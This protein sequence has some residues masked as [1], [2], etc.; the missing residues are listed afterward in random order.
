MLGAAVFVVGACSGADEPLSDAQMPTTTGIDVNV[1]LEKSP[2]VDVSEAL[3]AIDAAETSN[4]FCDVANALGAPLP[5][6]S[7]PAVVEVYERLAALVASSASLVPTDEAFPTLAADWQNL[8]DALAVAT[9]AITVA[10]GNTSDPVF[11]AALRGDRAT[12]A[13]ETVERFRA[14]RCG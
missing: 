5:T 7:S 6:T 13:A 11:V 10:D 8:G 9:E 14:E 4:D 2:D 1:G 12:T 3:S